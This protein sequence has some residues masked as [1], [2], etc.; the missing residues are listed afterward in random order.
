MP[1]TL[2]ALF[3]LVLA[4][5]LTFNQ[6]RLT[7]RSHH[8]MV[9][10]EIE[11]AAA[12]LA[13]EVI[14]FIDGRS[15]DEA[16]T[17]SAIGDANGQIPDDP[18]DFLLASTFGGDDNGSDGCNLVRPILTPDCDDVDD[19]HSQEWL[20]VDIQ[21]AAGRSLEFLVRTQVYY[22]ASP[23]SMDEAPSPTRHKRILV[24]I[25][26]PYLPEATEGVYRATRVIS[27]DPVKAEMDYEN[28][29]YY[30]PTYGEGGE[31]GGSGTHQQN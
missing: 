13:S 30:D 1:Q 10:D 11:L 14:A 5:F 16:S 18:S 22:V 12:G 27:Y 21:L 31:G 20:E 17:P 6:Q 7:L 9:T 3:A 4:S 28:S 29:D 24:D 15:F 8:N 23:E 25:R 2:L 26:S 19:V